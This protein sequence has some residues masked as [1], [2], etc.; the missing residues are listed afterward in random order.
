MDVRSLSGQ[1]NTRLH[2]APVVRTYKPNNEK[3]RQNV[4]YRG[5]STWNA[6]PFIDRNTNFNDFKTKIRRDKL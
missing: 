4:M 5:A 3:A 2:A 1:I 6:L